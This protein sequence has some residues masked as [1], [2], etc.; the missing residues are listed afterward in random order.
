MTI[1]TESNTITYQGDGATTVWSFSFPGGPDPDIQVYTRAAGGS[2]VLVTA[3]VQ[4]N[5]NPP[6]DPNPTSIGGNVVY[7]VTG[8]PL[9]IGNELII[10]RQVPLTQPTSFTNQ[11]TLYPQVIEATFDLVVM[12]IQQLQ[13]KIN[14]TFIEIPPCPERANK[15]LAFDANCNPVAVGNSN[16]IT[17]TNGIRV[18]NTE[19]IPELPCGN[20]DLGTLLALI[21]MAIQSS[22]PF[23]HLIPIH[24]LE[25]E[26][27]IPQFIH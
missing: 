14:Q 25:L 10:T 16:P 5:E 6:I 24:C 21:T 8:T 13:D 3:N 17:S 20:F 4:V 18:P 1:S 23:S 27:L 9:A 12:E 15:F 11:S 19:I 22:W 7:P 2:K 26:S